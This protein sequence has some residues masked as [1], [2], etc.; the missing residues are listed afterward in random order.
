MAKECREKNRVQYYKNRLYIAE[1]ESLQTARAQGCHD[2]L[3]AANFRQEKTIEIVTK[4]SY[5]NGFSEWTRDY[6][7]SCDEC[8]HS[9]S[10]RHAKYGLVQPL[11]VP[12]A[13]WSSKSTEFITQPAQS[14][15]KTQIMVAVD[16]FTKMAHFI[17]LHKNT[18]AMDVA[19]T[20]LRKFENIT[21]C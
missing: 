14:Q 6:V 9:K 12:Y 5:W 3:V 13:A 7:R 20:F 10:L 15:V 17:S 4:D 1:D 2:S 11:G 21:D 18:T 16:R 19:D 8:E